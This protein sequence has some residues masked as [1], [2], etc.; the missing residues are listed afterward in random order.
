MVKNINKCQQ[1][2]QIED[3]CADARNSFLTKITPVFPRL[4]LLSFWNLN[5]Q[6]IM[7][8]ELYGNLLSSNNKCHGYKYYDHKTEHRLERS[9]NLYVRYCDT[10][11]DV[12]E[13]KQAL[14]CKHVPRDWIRPTAA[15]QAE[16][17]SQGH[18]RTPQTEVPSKA[19]DSANH[20]S[21]SRAWGGSGSSITP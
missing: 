14:T 10:H 18:G 17:Q 20:A 3:S 1:P 19:L 9:M 12:A 21:H 4:C 2:P 8:I 15:E 11:N 6:H 16:R 7:K 13:A 5:E